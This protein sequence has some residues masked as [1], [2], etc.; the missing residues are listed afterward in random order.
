MVKYADGPTALQQ[1][2]IAAPAAAV[3]EIISDPSFPS[4]QSQELQRCDWAEDS[5]PP[6]VGATIRGHNH[7]KAVGEWSTT[8]TV[9]EW[10]EPN[11]W[12]WTV[13]DLDNPVSQWWFE[14]TETDGSTTLTQRVR[15]GPGPSGLTPAIERMPDREEE[16]VARRIAFIAENMAANLE[17]VRAHLEA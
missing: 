13:G 17:A 4:R 14:L 7:N 10:D 16:I 15:L 8:S 11:G 2:E 5:T 1:I 6:G 3:W 12:S 9:T